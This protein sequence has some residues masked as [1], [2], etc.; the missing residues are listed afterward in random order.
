MINF[1]VDPAVLASRLPPGTELD[2]F[3]GRTFVSLVGFLFEQT[4]VFGIPVPFHRNFEE[5][6]LR[7]Y[8]RRFADGGWRRGVV[9]VRELV[10]RAAIANIARTFYG[11]PYEAVPMSHELEQGGG[12]FRARYGWKHAGKA[13]FIEVSA[14]EQAQAIVA[15]SPEEFI[16]EHYWGYTGRPNGV[17]EYEVQHPVWQIHPGLGA[18]VQVEVARL[19]GAEFVP[20]LSTVPASCFVA[21]GSDVAVRWPCFVPTA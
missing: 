15:G 8:V 14:R 17:Q 18:S 6:N 4:R 7:F 2:F 13:Q 10:P 3:A 19:Y 16:A 11:E 5:V 12:R 1:E 20:A 9:F 21:V